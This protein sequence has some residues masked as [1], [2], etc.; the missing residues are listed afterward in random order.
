MG[1]RKDERRDKCIEYMVHMTTLQHTTLLTRT[2]AT[3][4]FVIV[5][6]TRGIKCQ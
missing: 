2:V 5:I 3:K 4:I 1:E 6:D